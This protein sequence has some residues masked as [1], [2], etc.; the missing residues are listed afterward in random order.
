MHS[1]NCLVKELDSIETLGR[2][3]SILV[4]KSRS[5]TKGHL[6]LAHM[7]IDGNVHTIDTSSK[8]NGECLRN[9]HYK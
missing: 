9:Q 6:S 4:D 3:S 1:K 5:L 8:Q 2:V 7:W